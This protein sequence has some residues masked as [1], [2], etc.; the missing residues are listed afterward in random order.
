[1]TAFPNYSYTWEI[2]K[3]NQTLFQNVRKPNEASKSLRRKT[4]QTIGSY[5]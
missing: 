2:R 5:L 1:M 4:F 3:E